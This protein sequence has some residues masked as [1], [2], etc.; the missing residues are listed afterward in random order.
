[1]LTRYAQSFVFFVPVGLG[2]MVGVA[3]NVLESICLNDGTQ[4]GRL[5][6]VRMAA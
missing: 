1:M 2:K 6:F 5:L 3:T 4:R